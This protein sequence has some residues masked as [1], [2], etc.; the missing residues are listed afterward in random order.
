MGN[1]QKVVQGQQQEFAQ[2]DHQQFLRGSQLRV[3][4]L[5]PMEDFFDAG[6]ITPLAKM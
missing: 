2:F 1:H 4:R 6:A 5:G 3:Q